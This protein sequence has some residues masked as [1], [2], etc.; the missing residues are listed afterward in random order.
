ME[1]GKKRD[2]EEEQEILETLEKQE[3]L[4]TLE[5]LKI[6]MEELFEK[7]HNN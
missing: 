4:E 1:K 6:R 2:K 3:I 7:K 5:K